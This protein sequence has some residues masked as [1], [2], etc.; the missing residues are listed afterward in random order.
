M[1]GSE[2]I[3]GPVPGQWCRCL[4]RMSDVHRRVQIVG[5]LEAVRPGSDARARLWV[6]DAD[7][8]EL[9]C[10]A[11]ELIPVE[12]PANGAG[13]IAAGELRHTT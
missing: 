11:C 5:P 8:V 3:P 2:R 10:R 6:I 7:G 13:P 1:C 12:V 9:V 4:D